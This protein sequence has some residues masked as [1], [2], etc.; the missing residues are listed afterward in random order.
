MR[1]IE[2]TKKSLIDIIILLPGIAFFLYGISIILYEIWKFRFDY[3]YHDV[4][5]D[6]FWMITLIFISSFI[7]VPSILAIGAY[8]RREK[9][10][11][12]LHVLSLLLQ[13]SIPFK[14]GFVPFNLIILL[15]FIA[16]FLVALF[17]AFDLKI[18]AFL[19]SLAVGVSLTF[20]S[21]GY[22]P[23]SS[24]IAFKSECPPNGNVLAG[25]F[26]FPYVEDVLGVSV[27]CYLGAED[28]FLFLPFLLDVLLY[29][30]IS[31]AGIKFIE[32]YTQRNKAIK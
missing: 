26:P 17:M 28:E 18:N 19:I 7:T 4:R 32:N 30:L 31:Y 27:M 5:G 20:A 24:G 9:A 11:F 16:S 1:S 10:G 6:L 25:G 29:A 21:Y 12:Y 23:F 3:R 13:V 15:P 14:L 22:Q 8:S 2:S